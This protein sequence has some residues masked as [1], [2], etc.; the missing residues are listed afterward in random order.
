MRPDV[1]I[2][3]RRFVKLVLDVTDMDCIKPKEAEGDVKDLAEI[4]RRLDKKCICHAPHSVTA[5]VDA[6]DSKSTGDA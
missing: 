2:V 6:A 4:F 3:P 5:S 1:E